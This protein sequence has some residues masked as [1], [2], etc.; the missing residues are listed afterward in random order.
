MKIIY[1]IKTVRG[2]APLSNG[3]VSRLLGSFMYSTRQSAVS[4]SVRLGIRQFSASVRISAV[5][6]FRS[7]RRSVFLPKTDFCSGT[8]TVDILDERATVKI[9]CG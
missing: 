4:A 1:G 3:S 7:V 8:E 5:S 2:C 6:V 9:N